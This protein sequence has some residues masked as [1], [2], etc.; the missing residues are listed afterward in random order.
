VSPLRHSVCRERLKYQASP[1][2][3]VLASA[4]RF[5]CATMSTS[6][7][8]ASV[9]TQVTSPSAS[10]LGTNAR[11]SST[12]SVEP[13]CAKGDGWSV[14]ATRSRGGSA[15]G[16]AH[17]GDET[18]LVVRVV[19]EAAGKLGGDG[20]GAGLL[21]PAHRHAHMFGLEH[22]RHAARGQNLLDRGR[23]LGGHVLL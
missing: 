12:S 5:M 16:P 6:P 10:N 21:D 20:R 22:D 17:H 4:S 8:R 1:V 11:P 15:I 19:R 23:D 18:D 13:R 3:M 7:E 2:A 9:A 14:K